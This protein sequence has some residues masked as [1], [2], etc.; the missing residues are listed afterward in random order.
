[1]YTSQIIWLIAIPLSI[2][3][4]Y[5]LILWLIRFLSKK[6]PDAFDESQEK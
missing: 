4:T 2:F 3:L 5:R 1:M 6:Y